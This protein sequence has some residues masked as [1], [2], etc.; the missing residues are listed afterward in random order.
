MKMHEKTIDYMEKYGGSFVAS[1]ALCYLR[2]DSVNRKT[3]VDAFYVFF[4]RYSKL[5]HDGESNDPTQ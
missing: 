2:A 3:L 5:A 1:L 4:S